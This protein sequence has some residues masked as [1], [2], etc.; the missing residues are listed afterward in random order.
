MPVV[1]YG[2]CHVLALSVALDYSGRVAAGQS[3]SQ[4]VAALA[5]TGRSGRDNSISSV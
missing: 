1:V 2:V 3:G 5:V 4:L